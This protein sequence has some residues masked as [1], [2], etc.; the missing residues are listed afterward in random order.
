MLRS[1]REITE[2]LFLKG[3][4]KVLVTTATLAWGVN[5]PAYATIIKGT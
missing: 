5:L 2:Q 4:I 1:D 3:N